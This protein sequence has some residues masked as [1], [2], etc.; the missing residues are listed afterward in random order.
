MN[1]DV[2]D[3]PTGA[4]QSAGY[5]DGPPA[6][7]GSN[8][9]SN[10]QQNW[11]SAGTVDIGLGALGTGIGFTISCENRRGRRFLR[12]LHPPNVVALLTRWSLVRML[13]CWRAPQSSSVSRCCSPA[14]RMSRK[15][16]R[17]WRQSLRKHPQALN[18]CCV[19]L[20]RR[21]RNQVSAVA[22]S[23]F[24]A[25]GL[26]PCSFCQ[27]DAEAISPPLVTPGHFG[28]GTTEL[29]VDITLVDLG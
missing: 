1:G 12:D 24:D 16:G 19:R 4:R 2:F 7:R 28:R 5:S 6:R 14:S 15:Q 10:I 3:R 21:R 11:H 13:A 29:L 20:S 9:T 17:S 25:V 27:V 26:Q 22:A 23:S 8:G 18:Q